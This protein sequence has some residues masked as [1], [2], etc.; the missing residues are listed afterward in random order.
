MNVPFP[1]STV[2]VMPFPS[3]PLVPFVPSTPFV[4][5]IPCGPAGPVKSEVV[6]VDPSV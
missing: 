4:P 3:T 6:K 1:L 5:A 2:L